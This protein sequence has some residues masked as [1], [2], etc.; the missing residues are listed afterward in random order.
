MH[1]FPVNIYLLKVKNGYIRT[2]HEISSKL[3]IKTPKQRHWHYFDILIVDFE[4]ITQ[5]AV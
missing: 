2:M 1:G 4:Q 3:T 5:Y